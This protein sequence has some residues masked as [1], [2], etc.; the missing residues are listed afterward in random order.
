VGVETICLV[1]VV[2]PRNPEREGSIGL[3]DP[4]FSRGGALSGSARRLWNEWPPQRRSRFSFHMLVLLAYPGRD[5]TSE[6][7]SQRRC[8]LHPL[9]SSADNRA[10]QKCSNKSIGGIRIPDESRHGHVARADRTTP[11]VA[12]PI[13]HNFES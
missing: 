11:P 8:T 1:A 9:K 10:G 13:Q 4:G 3:D 5:S 6:I 2:L 7:Y 12:N